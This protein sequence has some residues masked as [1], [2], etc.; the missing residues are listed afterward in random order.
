MKESKKMLQL[1]KQA[2]TG[3]NLV[4]LPTIQLT[5]EEA[6]KFIDC[7]YDESV[8]KSYARTEKMS[9]PTKYI[10]HLGFGDG[11]FLYPGTHFDESKYKKQWTHN[12]ITLEAKKIRGCVA[13]FD[14]DLE[15]GIEGPA[16]K[17]HLMSI[18][19]KQ[20]A[21]ELEFAN[22]MADTANYNPW[23]PT[24]IESLWDGWRYQITH[25]QSGQA[26][27]NDVCGA[28]DI[29]Q[30]CY[31]GSGEEWDHPGMIVEQDTDPPYNQEYKYAQMIKNMPA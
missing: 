8:M 23:C 3:Y 21:N 15:E 13:V 17:T 9:K 26:Y 4:A 2:I 25:S 29:K 16:F 10:R 22:Y 19:T 12:R 7:I 18:I 24:D 1:N 31:E 14:D 27:Y 5:P 6:T 20:I 28:A 30:A 11:K